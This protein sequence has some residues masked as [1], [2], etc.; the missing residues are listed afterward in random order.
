MPASFNIDNSH[1]E[2]QM[3]DVLL[4]SATE[5][6]ELGVSI[7]RNLKSESQISSCVVKSNKILGILV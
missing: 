1:Q 7:K 5:E 2:Y 6:K 4:T 3:Y